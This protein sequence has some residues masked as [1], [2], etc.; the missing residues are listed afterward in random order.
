MFVINAVYASVSL[1]LCLLLVIALHFLSPARSANW[2]SISQAIIFHQV[3]KYLLLLDSRKDHVK[4]WR[5]Q[6]LLLVQ[7]PRTAVPLISFVNA[8]KKSGLYVLGSRSDCVERCTST[9][10]DDVHFYFTGHVK[11]GSVTDSDCD[12]SQNEQTAWVDLSEH[13]RVRIDLLF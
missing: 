1:L 12:P 6:I 5:P 9:I 3:R 11:V 8:L 2:G 4:F 7:N 10:I 13:L